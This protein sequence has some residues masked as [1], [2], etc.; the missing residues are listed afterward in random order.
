MNTVDIDTLLD[1]KIFDKDTNQ[2]P[3]TK[4]NLEQN[5]PRILSIRVWGRECYIQELR[6]ELETIKIT[7]EKKK[8]RSKHKKSK[9]TNDKNLSIKLLNILSTE[10]SD[11][12]NNNYIIGMILYNIF[13]GNKEGLKHWIHSSQKIQKPHKTRG[14]PG[15]L[16]TKYYEKEWNRMDHSDYTIGTLIHYR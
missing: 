8:D 5:L 9:Y 2:I 6:E 12:H 11:D 7:R 4:N 13:N 10:R 14:T 16:N 1:Y 3:I 15:N